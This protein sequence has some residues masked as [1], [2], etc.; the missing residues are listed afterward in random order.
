M[1]D[2][3]PTTPDGPPAYVIGGG[4]AGLATA[5][6]LGAYG[7]PAVVVERSGAVAASWRRHYD[8]MTLH[9]TRRRS[10]LPGSP[11]PRSSG[12]WPGRD[13]MVRY[14]EQYAE[15]HRLEIVTGVEVSR[16]DRAPEGAG[17]ILRATG[18]REPRTDAVV[19]ATGL[20]H[21]PFVPAW[22][23]RDDFCGELLHAGHY[24]RPDRYRGRD[25]L[26]VGA[27]NT[28]ADVA[29]DLA[30][31]GAGR[32]RL[33]VRTAPHIVRRSVLGIPAQSCGILARR[34]P[35]RAVDRAARGLARVCLPDLAP[36]G[37]PQPETGM[38]ALLRAGAVPVVDTGIVRS[39][40]RGRVEPVA[41][42]ESFDGDKVRLADGTD[43][44]PD[45]VI[46]ATGYRRGL[47]DLVGHLEVLDEHG[48]PPLLGRRARPAAPGLYFTGYTN[49]VSGMLREIA[50]ES[51]RIAKAI[52]RERARAAAAGSG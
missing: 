7:V 50:A 17:W 51:H 25:V 33:A 9:T 29:L 32:V 34:L 48:R 39:I 14:L 12:R 37:L 20:N 41:A 26:V 45:T 2:I 21:T 52:A 49:P 3:T 18:G 15:E 23:G 13:A 10:A 42:V 27:G 44:A 38:S 46:A 47:E 6:V 8:R 11:I 5:A 43:I 16:V 30:Q 35:R 36:Y 19:V 22:P 24:R 31:G 40:G 28:G 4:P 1:S